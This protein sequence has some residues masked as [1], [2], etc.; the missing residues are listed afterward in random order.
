MGRSVRSCIE[1]QGSL[2]LPF[3]AVSSQVCPEFAFSVPSIEN[4]E[5]DILDQ[6]DVWIDFSSPAQSMQFLKA[7]GSCR[8]PVVS[9]TT[10]FTA[11]Q[12]AY[13]K[14]NSRQRPVFW[15]SN[16]SIGIWV[17]RQALKSLGAIKNFDFAVD[18]SHHR[19][20][21]DNPSGT[22]KT[23]HADLEKI[24]FKKVDLSRGKR[25]GGIFGIHEITAA[26]KSEVLS[27]KHTALNREVFADGALKA[28]R[29]IVNKKNGFYSMEDL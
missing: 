22:A 29:W 18:E 28:A 1:Q 10:G 16:M 3:I 15:A 14:K 24:A 20:K 27:F 26:S 25:L 17:L 21:K 2:F 19:F 6:V 8:I 7:L 13:L 23:L 5:K 12:F 9:G 4:T 11:D